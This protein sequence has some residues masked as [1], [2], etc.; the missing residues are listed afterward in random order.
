MER[1]TTTKRSA[2]MKRRS[3]K[4]QIR[5]LNEA[6]NYNKKNGNAEAAEYFAIA[7]NKAC[8]KRID[9][10]TAMGLN[11]WLKANEAI[12]TELE[13]VIRIKERANA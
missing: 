13:K 5:N 4:Q 2:T 3:T 10:I 1:N 9:E 7:L 12:S 8:N 11:L 6:F